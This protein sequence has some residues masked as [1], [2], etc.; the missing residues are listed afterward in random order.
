MSVCYSIICKDCKKHLWIG[1]SSETFYSGE[2]QTMEALRIFFFNHKS[3]NLMFDA[4]KFYDYMLS[5]DWEEINEDN[6]KINP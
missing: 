3:H 5:D 4:P 6:N 1:Q 2:P